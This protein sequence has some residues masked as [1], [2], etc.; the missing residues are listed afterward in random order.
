MR[1]AKGS[2]RGRLLS[3]AA[4]LFVSYLCVALSLPLV[5]VYVTDGLGLGNA[6]GG[7]AVG[8]AFLA[9][10]VSRGAAG[11]IA[12]RRGPKLALL[13]GLVLYVI[14]SLTS[15]GAVFI[16]HAPQAA[17]GL[18]LLGRVLLGAGQSLV[19][20]G[21]IAW[22][23][24]LVG[25]HRSGEVLALVGATTYGALAIGGPAGFA[26][27]HRS[28]FA[29][30]LLVG[31]VLPCLGCAAAS[32]LR[33]VPPQTAGLRPPFRTVIGKVGPYGSVICLQGIGF[34]AI[35]AFFALYFADHH[36]LHGAFGLTSFGA[37]FVV[38][39]LFFGHLPD[40]IGGLLVAIASLVVQATGQALIGVAPTSSAALVGAFMT[41]LGA[42]L[43]FPAM[44]REVVRV[45]EPHLRA[46]AL[47]AFSAFQDLA[48]GLTG[49]TAGL[50]ID[51]LGFRSVF[52]IGAG[53]SL[54]GLFVTVRLHRQVGLAARH[55]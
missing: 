14:G 19:S 44:G 7:L 30:V 22:G 5:S 9:T 47:G 21:V 3:L 38:V 32:R 17:F 25:P 48:Y 40:R 13:G 35:A 49:P 33:D 46:T 41:G 16:I 55:D 10:V 20:V 36:W 28:S 39:R 37:G 6:L 18:F 45:I 12:D 53:C 27:F 29:G 23:I 24:G 54:L 4:I 51:R 8:A 42:S 15:L 50:L 43:M 26:L 11:S 31:T 34:A 1:N 52:L 2:G